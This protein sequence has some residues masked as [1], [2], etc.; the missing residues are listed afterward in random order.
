MK[1]NLKGYFLCSKEVGMIILK[2]K[3]GKIINIASK[4]GVSAS[5]ISFHYN[6][7]KAGVIML[8]KCLALVLAPYVK[9]NGIA[10]GFIQ[11]GMNI[12]SSNDYKRRVIEETPLKKLGQSQDV[13]NACIF[14]SSNESDFINGHIINVDGGRGLPYTSTFL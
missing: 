4:L 10:P 1:V 14:L 9:V 7:A 11:A 5:R 2:Q 3:S 12:Y 8:T 6:V 13:A